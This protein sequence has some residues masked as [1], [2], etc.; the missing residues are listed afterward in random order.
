MLANN[1]L[2]ILIIQ[3]VIFIL[4]FINYY[5]FLL[6]Y[7]YKIIFYLDRDLELHHTNINQYHILNYTFPFNYNCS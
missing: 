3:I 5:I 4:I 6:A 2:Y 1:I 7:V